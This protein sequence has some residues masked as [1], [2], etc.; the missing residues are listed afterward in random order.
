MKRFLKIHKNR[1]CSAFVIALMAVGVFGCGKKAQEDTRNFVFSLEDMQLEDGI[2]SASGFK[3]V[4]T[5]DEIVFYGTTNQMEENVAHFV[6]YDK[7][8]EVALY[9]TVSLGPD[10]M[11]K[12]CVT[13]EGD[14]Y[15]LLWTKDRENVPADDTMEDGMMG[16][17]FAGPEERT[18]ENGYYF[19]LAKIDKNG[20]IVVDKNVRDD[21]PV[22]ALESLNDEYSVQNFVCDTEHIFI[23]TSDSIIAYDYDLNCL[24]VLPSQVI[25]KNLN[26]ASYFNSKSGD[27]YAMYT[28]SQY[29]V[30]VGK[31]DLITGTVDKGE[32]IPGAKYW[33][34]ISTGVAKDFLYCNNGCLYEFNVGDVE[35]TKV[36][37]FTAS[38]VPTDNIY[39]AAGFDEQHFIA[40]Y[41]SINDGSTCIG[42]FCKVNPEDVREKTIIDLAV[43]D[44]NEIVRR[45]VYTFNQNNP[46]Y[47]IRILN[48]QAM[49]SDGSGD[50]STAISKLNTDIV[51]GNM[52]DI[53]LVGYSIPINTY[54]SK[55]LIEDLNPYIDADPE[56]KRGDFNEHILDVFSKDGKLYSLVPVY[57]VN[58]VMAKKSVV[59]DSFSWSID[60][61]MSIFNN[62]GAN[63]FFVWKNQEDIIRSCIQMSG[64]RF[65][66]VEKAECNFNSDE[67]KKVLEFTKN[68]IP[69]GDMD[70]DFMVKQM[71]DSENWFRNNKVICQI[72]SV[73]DLVNYA[74]TRSATFGDTV[75]CIGFPCDGGEIG[76][77]IN[78]ILNFCIS[79]KSDNK[80]LCWKFLRYFLSDEFQNDS[81]MS[82]YGF[83][84]KESAFEEKLKKG[85]DPNCMGFSWRDE[86]G[87]EI[88][89]PMNYW[90]NGEE[91]ELEPLTDEEIDDIRRLIATVNKNG[92]VDEK[93]ISIILEEAKEYYEDNATIDDVCKRIQSRAQIYIY[94]CQ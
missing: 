81:E 9:Y 19:E 45:A 70:Y 79:S 50:L 22:A 89:Y 23:Q 38:G 82:G 91:R 42:N 55:N 83:P 5:R 31:V 76:S 12:I 20:E 8:G 60:D 54:I 92:E 49:Y 48:Y 56:F 78:P 80:E 17:G 58:T 25:D 73:S 37:D 52:P 53:L 65:V 43:M 72:G 30:V 26:Y 71:G 32:K 3:L 40:S 75:A 24:N 64:G 74:Y 77:S 94:E 7:N 6:Y 67:F 87:N 59:G 41:R 36:M 33:A 14:V 86:E 44:D 84:L 46:D 85:Q 29:N 57:S 66:D 39:C 10:N 62:V 18:A 61:A 11:D 16:E 90:V 35:L 68:C 1:I 34:T 21:E 47:S 13:E 88:F 63:Q 93:I 69:S 51:S 28:D 27:L 4:K 2:T 15:A